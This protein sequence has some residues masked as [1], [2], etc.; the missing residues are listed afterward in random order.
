MRL[1]DA[2]ALL[3]NSKIIETAYKEDGRWWAKYSVDVNDIKEAPTIDAVPAPVRCGECKHFYCCSAIDR[4]FY[5]KHQSGLKHV[6]A[7]E[8]DSF[9]SYGERKDGEEK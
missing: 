8:E 7:V 2:N 1:I 5:C 6:K 3:S 4:M 9:C